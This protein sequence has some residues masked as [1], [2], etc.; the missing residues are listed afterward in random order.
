MKSNPDNSTAFLSHILYDSWYELLTR[1]PLNFD[2]VSLYENFNPIYKNVDALSF[3]V[4][5]EIKEPIG[6]KKYKITK[7][8][9]ETED[10]VE[11][12]YTTRDKNNNK[13][14]D[15]VCNSYINIINN[16]FIWTT[17]L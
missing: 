5:D 10:K 13:I 12:L 7:K 6:T 9:T 4:P 8:K 14:F 17:W 3:K 16:W 11:D 1:W 15:F 2:N